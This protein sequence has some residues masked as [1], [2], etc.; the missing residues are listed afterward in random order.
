MEPG[1]TPIRS[2][3]TG[4]RWRREAATERGK[5]QRADETGYGKVA[6][7]NRAFSRCLGSPG[8]IAQDAAG[9][10]CGRGRDRTV[11]GNVGLAGYDA[12]GRLMVTDILP[13][14]GSFWHA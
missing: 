12:I 13:G 6:A 1:W 8:G 5:R 14:S 2:P 4:E 7:F 11:P 9:I 10:R 3:G